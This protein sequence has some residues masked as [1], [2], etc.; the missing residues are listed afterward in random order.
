M[1]IVRRL[2]SEDAPFDFEGEFFHYGGAFSSV[3]PATPEGIPLFFG[4]ASPP[5]I[6]VG[7][8][9]ADVYAF[10]GEPRAAVA[11]RMAAIEEAASKHGRT[12]RYS[13]SLRPIIARRPRR[14]PGRR[15]R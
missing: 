5:A 4:G 13:L 10:W 2:W 3:K 8:T 6:E 14:R 15:P 12:L 11:G 1:S 9:Q 7:A